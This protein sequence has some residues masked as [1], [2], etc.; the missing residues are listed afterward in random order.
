MLSLSEETFDSVLEQVDAGPV[1]QGARRKIILSIAKLRD[2]YSNLCHLEQASSFLCY[3]NF[4]KF[5][6]YSF[7]NKIV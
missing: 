5:I 2:R 4:F 6:S 1:T 3:V 7:I